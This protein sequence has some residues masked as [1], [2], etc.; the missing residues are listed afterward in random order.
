MYDLLQ[1]IQGSDTTAYG[2]ESICAIAKKGAVVALVLLAKVVIE[3]IVIECG[4]KT[5]VA[6]KTVLELK[7]YGCK[8]R[9]VVF[10]ETGRE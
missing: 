1:V 4:C 7:E 6:A 8:A 9:G 10:N 3:G 5:D 2:A